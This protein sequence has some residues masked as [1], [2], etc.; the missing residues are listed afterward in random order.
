MDMHQANWWFTKILFDNVK[1]ILNL[2]LKEDSV[3]LRRVKSY[4][5]ITPL[6][7]IYYDYIYIVIS[8]K[9]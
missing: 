9:Y 8:V 4:I 1:I 5:F 2:L 6:I 7:N 3:N